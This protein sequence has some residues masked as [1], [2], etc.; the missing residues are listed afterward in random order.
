MN[1]VPVRRV[2]TCVLLLLAVAVPAFSQ[3]LK[4]TEEMIT[5]YLAVYDT[6]LASSPETASRLFCN[7]RIEPS[8]PE[9]AMAAAALSRA[10][11]ESQEDFSAAD[12]II[13]TAWLQLTAE[14]MAESA[15]RTKR[16]AVTAIE[17]ALADP[18]IKDAQRDE[19]EQT[20]E[21]LQ[22]EEQHAA[23]ASDSD[24]IDPAGMALIRSY[25]DR[26]RPI[27]TMGSDDQL[28]GF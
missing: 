6:V 14:E 12:V 27:M 16:D 9:G 21:Q 3:V 2:P 8:T 4:V 22:K 18:N 11:F 15:E 19:L 10:G 25:R 17:D 23:A 26:L 7:E 13:G 5:R 20:L 28:K 24:L 1:I